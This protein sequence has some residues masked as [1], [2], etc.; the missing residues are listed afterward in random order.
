MSQGPDLELLLQ[1][2]ATGRYR[3]AT[4]LERGV[5]LPLTTPQPARRPHPPRRAQGAGADPAQPRGHRGRLHPALVRAARFLRPLA[6]RPRAVGPGLHPAAA[7]PGRRAR[8]SRAGRRRGLGRPRRRPRGGRRRGGPA[9]RHG[10]H[11][12]RAAAAADP[13]GRAAGQ[14][15][16]AAGTRQS[17]QHPAARARRAEA[18]GGA[19][20]PGTGPGDRRGESRSPSPSSACARTPPRPSRASCG[21]CAA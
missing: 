21:T 14:Q 1:R 9:G 17:R 13:P 2:Y 19:G 18:P 6:A 3:P 5:A 11:A 4:F 15:P 20:Q 16:T 7:H 8:S 12:V 10:S